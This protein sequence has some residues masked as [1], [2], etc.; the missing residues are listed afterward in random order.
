MSAHADEP[1]P[2]RF[3][4]LQGQWQIDEAL[5]DLRHRGDWPDR[6]PEIGRAH[7]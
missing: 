6:G 5:S 4:V 7:V 1:D 3:A 2:A